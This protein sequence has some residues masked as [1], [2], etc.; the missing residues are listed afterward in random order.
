MNNIKDHNLAFLGGSYSAAFFKAKDKLHNKIDFYCGVGGSISKTL[1]IDDN[2]LFRFN[3]V[4]LEKDKVKWLRE[5]YEKSTEFNEFCSPAE[6]KSFIIYTNL[7]IDPHILFL[8]EP[9]ATLQT[10]FSSELVRKIML[11]HEAENNDYLEQLDQIKQLAEK[12]KNW[13][14]RAN[15]YVFP[16]PLEIEDINNPSDQSGL[17]ANQLAKIL[18]KKI[19][20]FY[21]DEHSLNIKMPPLETITNSLKTRKQYCTLTNDRNW[22]LAI[23]GDARENHDQYTNARNRHRNKEYAIAHKKLIEEILKT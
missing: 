14:R 6:Y 9:N 17:A 19:E 1:D 5:I 16:T 13:N 4:H 15:I 7:K 22:R 12:L 3:P 18:F 2:Q 10:A 21:I 11:S 23:K 8:G 20:D